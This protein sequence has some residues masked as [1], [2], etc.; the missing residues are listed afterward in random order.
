MS[1]SNF[2]VLSFFCLGGQLTVC[3][4]LV[5]IPPFLCP[6]KP[7]HL[8]SQLISLLFFNCYEGREKR[9]RKFHC[10]SLYKLY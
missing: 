6:P 5:A 3:L 9:L 2:F 7:Y 10:N 4:S 8:V 1:S